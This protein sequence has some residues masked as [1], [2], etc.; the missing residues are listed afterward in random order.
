MSTSATTAFQLNAFIVCLTRL[1]TTGLLRRLAR[2]YRPGWFKTFSRK[3]GLTRDDVTLLFVGKFIEVKRAHDILRALRILQNQGLTVSAVYVGDGPLRSSL[4]TEA[5]RSGVSAHFVGFKNQSELPVYYA[6][7]DALVLPSKSETWG[8]VVNEAMAT[9]TPAIVSD[10][11]G[12]RPDLIVEGETGYSYPVGDVATLASAVEQL[13]A[14]RSEGHDFASSARNLI[15]C[16][17]V[18]AA[19]KGVVEAAHAVVQS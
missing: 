19:A 3:L 17:S 18:E 16:Y 1:T 12:C 14:D 15:D 7:A 5:E 11:V 2:R 4:T 6:L 9:G 13:I 8:L 10:A